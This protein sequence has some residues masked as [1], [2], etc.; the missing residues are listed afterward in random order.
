MNEVLDKDSNMYRI[1]EACRGH[2]LVKISF[3]NVSYSVVV[4]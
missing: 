4:S 3:K 1:Y 2:T